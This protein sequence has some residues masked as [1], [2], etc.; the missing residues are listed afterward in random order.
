[1]PHF[2][3]LLQKYAWG[4]RIAFVSPVQMD[5]IIECPI[6][7]RVPSMIPLPLLIRTSSSNSSRSVS[8]DTLV[9]PIDEGLAEVPLARLPSSVP[10]VPRGTTPESASTDHVQHKHQSEA[11]W[12]ETVV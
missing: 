3:A 6:A 5:R 2:L 7:P 10:H 12:Q 8:S 1:M 9:T 11:M 4:I